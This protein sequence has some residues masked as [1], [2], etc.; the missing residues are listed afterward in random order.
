MHILPNPASS[1]NTLSKLD[2]PQ[3]HMPAQHMLMYDQTM[4]LVYIIFKALSQIFK[5]LNH[6]LGLSSAED[7]HVANICAISCFATHT[8]CT[9][10]Y[11]LHTN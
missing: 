6:I 10:L 11:E 3:P 2:F 9:A 7:Y 4:S 1:H 5:K 8:A